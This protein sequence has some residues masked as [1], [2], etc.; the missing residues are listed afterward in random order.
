MKIWADPNKRTGTINGLAIEDLTSTV[1]SADFQ[2]TP[3][4][5]GLTS[6]GTYA[7]YLA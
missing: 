1:R 6:T 7:S 4:R 5:N 2:S 3:A